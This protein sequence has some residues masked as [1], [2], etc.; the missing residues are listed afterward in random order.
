MKHTSLNKVDTQ[1]DATFW[2][3]VELDRPESG[4]F[5]QFK[6]ACQSLIARRKQART[7]NQRGRQADHLSD[8]LLD[9][10][11]ISRTELRYVDPEY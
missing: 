1:M 8:N 3:A 4:L 10:I 11:G 5:D 7:R 9:D 2:Q 6:H